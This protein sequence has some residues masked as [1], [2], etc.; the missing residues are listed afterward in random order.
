GDAR[1]WRFQ[2]G[3]RSAPPGQGRSSGCGD[4]QSNLRQ[5]VGRHRAGALES[6]EA[7]L[8]DT[9]AAARYCAAMAQEK[10]ER[11]QR[12]LD[13][14]ARRDEATWSEQ[15]RPEVEAVPVDDWP[16]KEIRGREAVWDFLVA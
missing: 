7:S 9:S 2:P 11:M 6:E 8:G 16:E 15:C 12:A 3:A 1:A 5:A 13:A 14:F 4:A 10:V